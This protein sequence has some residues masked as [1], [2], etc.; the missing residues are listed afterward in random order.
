MPSDTNSFY[1]G[2][3][4]LDGN[5]VEEKDIHLKLDYSKPEKAIQSEQKSQGLNSSFT[6]QSEFVNHQLQNCKN[7]EGKTVFDIFK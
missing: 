7:Q 6:N 4:D 2:Y 1:I 5:F 3:F